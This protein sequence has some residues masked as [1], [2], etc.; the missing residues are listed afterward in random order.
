MRLGLKYNIL[1]RYTTL[2]LCFLCH[3]SLNVTAADSEPYKIKSI[4]IDAGHGGKD[5]GCH[6]SKGTLE[7]T[8]ALKVALKLGAYIKEAYPNIKVYYTRM[9]D[10]FIEL[11]ERAAIANRNK[12]DL[13]ISIHCNANP[14]TTPYGTETYV[15]GLHK[16][17]DNLDVA[18]RENEV[19]TLEKDYIKNYDGYDPKDPATHIILSLNQHA[20]LSQ[21]TLLAQKVQ[22]QYA[23]TLSRNNRGVKQAGFVVLY[24]TTMPSI[25]T[26]IGFLTNA[27]EESYLSSSKGQDFIASALYRAFKEYKSA[28]EKTSL[29]IEEKKNYA[30]TAGIGED[31]LPEILV[32]QIS[33]KENTNFQPTID[34]A[35]LLEKTTPVEQLP[36]PPTVTT[37]INIVPQNNPSHNVEYLTTYN[38]DTI[39]FKIQVAATKQKIATTN[40][41]IYSLPKLQIEF[42]SDLSIYRYL[43][44]KYFSLA[45]AKKQLEVIK[46]KGFKDAFIAVYQQ[47]S[48]LLPSDAQKYLEQ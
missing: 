8:V 47:N 2:L 48:R 26:E 7:K 13:F 31:P 3:H 1:A 22:N 38:G 19:I 30:D 41:S 10:N 42:N 21:S 14:S 20:H 5:N 23:K 6:G 37:T 15:L 45:E 25:L 29:I 46:N 44:G 36:S 35:Q 32:E 33:V 43:S 11:H 39:S 17:A 12:A 27:N 9:T 34:T 18:K 4:V 24:R 28:M 16:T 40:K